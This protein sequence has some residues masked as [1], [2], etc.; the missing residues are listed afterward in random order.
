MPGQLCP[1]P[2]PA[3]NRHHNLWTQGKWYLECLPSSPSLKYTKSETRGLGVSRTKVNEVFNLY[4]RLLNHISKYQQ[5]ALSTQF[6]RK[7]KIKASNVR[8]GTI[9]HFPYAYTRIKVILLS[10]RAFY[11]LIHVTRL[12]QYLAHN[13]VLNK[14][15]LA[16]SSIISNIPRGERPSQGSLKKRIY[17]LIKGE[18]CTKGLG[19]LFLWR[20]QALPCLIFLIIRFKKLN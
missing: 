16:I 4:P 5:F 10:H 1:T 12:A 19:Q 15:V 7:K 13:Y 18:K 17:L 8:W 14:R 9:Y 3:R 20:L 2:N 11:E 6:E